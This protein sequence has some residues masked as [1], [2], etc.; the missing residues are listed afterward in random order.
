MLHAALP[1]LIRCENKL[2]I[3]YTVK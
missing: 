3:I 1:I 2:H